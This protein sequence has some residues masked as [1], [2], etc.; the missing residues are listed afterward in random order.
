M[1]GMAPLPPPANPQA[2]QAS[3]GGGIGSA[4]GK[5]FKV[6]LLRVGLAFVAFVL[7]AGGIWVYDKI[8]STRAERERYVYIVNGTNASVTPQING[9][10]IGTALAPWAS[11]RLDV[12]TGHYTVSA[13]VQGK[14]DQGSFDVPARPSFTSGLR[15]IYTIGGDAQYALL[16]AHYTISGGKPTAKE[17]GD[18]ARYFEVKDWFTGAPDEKFP[19]SVET[20]SYGEVTITHICHIDDDGHLPCHR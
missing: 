10:A 5:A 16:T 1:P 9:K 11:Y 6:Q 7:L 19:E 4:I 20:D 2:T 13:D 12:D 14:P 8:R 15:G 3:S 18:G 17:V